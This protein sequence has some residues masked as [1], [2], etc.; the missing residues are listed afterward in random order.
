MCTLV[1]GHICGTNQAKNYYR[2]TIIQK[3]RVGA[4]KL[5]KADVMRGGAMGVVFYETT[6]CDH[7]PVNIIV[8]IP[9][10]VCY[11]MA[12]FSGCKEAVNFPTRI[13]V[14]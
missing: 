8:Q 5:L 11:T 3:Q 14:L 2:P 1:G 10:H 6:Y 12:T 13:T 7:H 9:K 4:L